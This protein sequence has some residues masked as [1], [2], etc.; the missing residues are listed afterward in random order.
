MFLRSAVVAIAVVIAL[1]APTWAHASMF[2]ANG[3]DP[4]FCQI[5]TERQTVIYIDDTVMQPGS[6]TW[7][8]DLENKLEGTLTPGE[9]VTLVRLSPLSA[10]TVELWSACWPDYP[11]DQKAKLSDGMFLFTSNP[12]TDLKNQQAIFID[13]LLA[14]ITSIYIATKDLPG[15]A[16]VDGGHPRE[17]QIVEALSSDSARFTEDDLTS[18]IIVYSDLAENSDLGSAFVPPPVPF[19]NIGQK[20]GLQFHNSIFYFF[21][22]GA[23]VSN[24]QWFLGKCDSI[25]ATGVGLD[26][27]CHGG[28]WI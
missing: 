22:V 5:P 11:A 4:K 25:L 14:K 9:K 23:D 28:H 18:R 17:K 6:V 13:E 27:R 24:A 26:R 20:L 16:T 2:G 8:S 15:E 21:G 7:V 3:L 1:M 19:P 10:T 12:L